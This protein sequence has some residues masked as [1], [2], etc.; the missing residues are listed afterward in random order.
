MVAIL[1]HAMITY[2]HL[3]IRFPDG[4]SQIYHNKD[5][6]KTPE[7]SFSKNLKYIQNSETRHYSQKLPL[8]I[9]FFSSY[10]EL[11]ANSHFAYQ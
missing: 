1:S 11:Q 10:F 9:S 4:E 6:Q 2:N 8:G 7:G 5:H 3:R